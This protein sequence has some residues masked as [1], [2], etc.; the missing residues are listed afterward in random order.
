MCIVN[1]FIQSYAHLTL[2]HHLQP[3]LNELI[4]L[5]NF[6]SIGVMQICVLIKNVL[7]QSYEPHVL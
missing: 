7:I 3:S 6:P 1:F 4:N 5:G 2:T